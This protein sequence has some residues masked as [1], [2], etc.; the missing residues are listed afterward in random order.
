MAFLISEISCFFFTSYSYSLTNLAFSLIFS[1][2]NLLFSDVLTPES[3][4]VAVFY[5]VIDDFWTTGSGLS[6]ASIVV[7][8]GDSISS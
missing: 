3:L 7:R 2:S 4:L 8:S 5:K 1:E 6:G